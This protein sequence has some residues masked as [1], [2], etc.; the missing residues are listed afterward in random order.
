MD[1]NRVIKETSKTILWIILPIALLFLFPNYVDSQAKQKAKDFCNSIQINESLHSLLNKCAA[2][3]AKC[4]TWN[5]ENEVTR[6]QAWFSDFLLKAY[7]CNIRTKN[8]K[9][10]LK[11]YEEFTD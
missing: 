11:G 9:V 6:H 5:P 8:D 3:Q 4:S 2:T 1:I 10:I 7:T